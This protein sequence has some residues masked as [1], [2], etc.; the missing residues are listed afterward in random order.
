MM[1]ELTL[2]FLIVVVILPFEFDSI[3]LLEDS[4]YVDPTAY[5]FGRFRQFHVDP[6]R[7]ASGRV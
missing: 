6:A 4:G 5:S 1:L 2:L 7:G 3:R